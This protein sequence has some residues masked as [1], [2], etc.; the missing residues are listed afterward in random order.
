MIIL[1]AVVVSLALQVIPPNNPPANQP[2]PRRYDDYPPRDERD[3]RY[4]VDS[5]IIFP[6]KTIG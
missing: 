1:I 6:T 5:K 3:R 4:R 2:S